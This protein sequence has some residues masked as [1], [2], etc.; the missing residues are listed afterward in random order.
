M[1]EA[2]SSVFTKRGRN[3]MTPEI[4]RYGWIDG[5]VAFE[6]SKGRGMVGERIYGVTFADA[7]DPNTTMDES[8]MVMTLEAADE[9]IE[10]VKEERNAGN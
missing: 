9:L 3:F 8:S 6:V 2:A 7:R 4:V 5:H 1:P 10:L